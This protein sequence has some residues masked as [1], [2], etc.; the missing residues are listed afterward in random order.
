MPKKPKH[1]ELELITQATKTE[2]MNELGYKEK[3]C[4]YS[5]IFTIS[6][7]KSTFDKQDFRAMLYEIGKRKHHKEGEYG[8]ITTNMNETEYHD[9]YK[10]TGGV[11]D[12]KELES[13]GLKQFVRKNDLS[14][15]IYD[16]KTKFSVFT[17]KHYVTK[18]FQQ[19]G[20]NCATYC[21]HWICSK[22]DMNC[23]KKYEAKVK[24]SKKMLGAQVKFMN[25]VDKKLKKHDIELDAGYSHD[26]AVHCL[27]PAKLHVD[28]AEDKLRRGVVS[29]IVDQGK[30]VVFDPGWGETRELTID[31]ANK[32]IKLA[33]THI[34]TGFVRFATLSAF[35]Y[36]PMWTP[37]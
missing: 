20:G 18:K 7:A 14:P 10:S 6:E 22:K 19:A 30:F 13:K 16:K 12:K 33:Q 2:L 11:S 34:G 15:S 3:G 32:F 4:L 31:A 27:K 36:D 29:K 28:W 26:I 24:E 8:I 37:K 1:V 35:M 21:L 23:L 25:N 9:C 5:K 17:T